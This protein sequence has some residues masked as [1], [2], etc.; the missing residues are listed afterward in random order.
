MGGV[1]NEEQL[2]AAN[3]KLIE[4]LSASLVRT[5]SRLDELA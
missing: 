4:W 1:G 5:E 3:Q 2:V